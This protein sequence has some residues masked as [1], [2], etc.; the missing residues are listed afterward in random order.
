M[1]RKKSRPKPFRVTG[2]DVSVRVA[3]GPREDGRW[4]W[5]ADHQVGDKR[6]TVWSGWATQEEAERAV[7][8]ALKPQP[9][10]EP[11]QLAPELVTV[12]DLLE[13]W[14]ASIEDRADLTERS[15]RSMDNAGKRLL[16]HGLGEVRV[17]LVDRGTLERWRDAALRAGI[18]GSTASR[19]LKRLRQAWDWAREIGEIPNRMLPR[20]C[21]PKRLRAPVYTHYTPSRA[22]MGRLLEA[23]RP[24]WVRRSLI[25]LASTGARIGEIA[26]L[27]WGSVAADCA[28]IE[29]CGKTGPRRVPLHPTVAAEVA[30]WARGPDEASVLGVKANTAVVHTQRKLAEASLELGLPRV[31]PNGFRRAMTDALYDAGALPDVEAAILGH[32]AQTALE[33]YRKVGERAKAQAVVAAGIELPRAPRGEAI[34]FSGPKK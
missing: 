16:Q 34:P 24:D 12:R 10:P 22:E 25:L 17:E 14:S 30:R 1:P 18:A 27:T 21:V 8:A 6:P 13:T 5:R 19:D 11:V 28:S 33:H 29:V 7:V 23:V 20:V 15:K 31:S 26:T 32:S 3:E 4:R 9:E 2:T